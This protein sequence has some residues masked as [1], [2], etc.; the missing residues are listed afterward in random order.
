MKKKWRLKILALFIAIFL[1]FQQSLIRD[2]SQEINIP[3]EIVNIPNNYIVFS[4]TANSLSFEIKARGFDLL[5]MKFMKKITYKIDAEKFNYWKNTIPVSSKY[6]SIPT[7]I[8]LNKIKYTDKYQKINIVLDKLIRDKKNIIPTFT[9]KNA[10][11]FFKDKNIKLIPSLVTVIGPKSIV[12]QITGIPTH[13]ISV[14]D[15]K[16]QNALV[17]LIYLT[18]KIKIYPDQ[19]YLKSGKNIFKTKIFKNIKIQLPNYFKYKII[20][21]SIIVKVEGKNEDIDKITV[22][23]IYANIFKINKDSTSAEINVKINKNVKII[24]FTPRIIQVLK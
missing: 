20:P 23:D 15:L 4:K 8:K 9:D 2:Y 18:P 24:E 16:K 7:N 1:W 11:D 17:K 22:N 12:K 19:T 14:S 21:T 10:G 5:L 13:K 3:I 6:L